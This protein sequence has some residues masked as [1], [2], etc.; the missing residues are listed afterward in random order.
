[1]LQAE[2]PL[3]KATTLQP[4]GVETQNADEHAVTAAHKARIYWD[5][6]TGEIDFTAPHGVVPMS[7]ATAA[8]RYT[9]QSDPFTGGQEYLLVVRIAT[10]S[11]PS[12]IEM[13]N[14]DAHACAPERPVPV[15]PQL[16]AHVV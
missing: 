16:A 10:A 6:G 11:Y 8:I 9:W 1:M 13:E 14:T 7:N 2:S 15:V 3:G 4:S 5:A 12:G